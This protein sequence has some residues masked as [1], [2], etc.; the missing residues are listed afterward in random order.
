[1]LA[2]ADADSR[3]SACICAIMR[4]PHNLQERPNAQ[5][6]GANLLI[7]CSAEVKYN[8]VAPRS[9]LQVSGV[10]FHLEGLVLKHGLERLFGDREIAYVAP[11]RPFRERNVEDSVA[12][13]F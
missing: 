4:H 1:M 9:D 8:L 5:C 13:G 11:A 6:A 3:Q 7:P 10:A 2:K 12:G